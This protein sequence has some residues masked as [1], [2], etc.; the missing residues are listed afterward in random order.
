MG[1]YLFQVKRIMY[2]VNNRFMFLQFGT[3]LITLES[4]NKFLVLVMLKLRTSDIMN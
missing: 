4:N 2:E 1:D 3:N